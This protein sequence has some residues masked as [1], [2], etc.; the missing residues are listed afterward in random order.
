MASLYLYGPRARAALEFME[1][2]RF[3][4]SLGERRDSS[5]LLFVNGYTF[6]MQLGI[7]FTRKVSWHTF[8][9]MVNR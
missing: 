6:V 3:S 4:P 2:V 7:L 1:L 5:S 8:A 9:T